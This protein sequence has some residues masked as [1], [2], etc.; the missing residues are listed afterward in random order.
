MGMSKW[1]TESS[2]SL[3]SRSE[4]EEL[5]FLSGFEAFLGSCHVGFPAS[6]VLLAFLDESSSTCFGSHFLH[7]SHLYGLSNSL[8]AFLLVGGFSASLGDGSFDWASFLAFEFFKFFTLF[9]I[10]YS[11]LIVWLWTSSTF[12]AKLTGSEISWLHFRVLMATCMV[13]SVTTKITCTF[14][15][16]EVIFK[17]DGLGT[18]KEEC[19]DG[20]L[21]LILII[22]NKI[23]INIS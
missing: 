12:Q 1:L 20:K 8:G 7:H 18:C 6:L 10:V 16:L 22:Q 13:A 21:H 15:F 14:E 5:V 17:A 19:G 2:L 11:S 3:E 23:I 9:V 4:E